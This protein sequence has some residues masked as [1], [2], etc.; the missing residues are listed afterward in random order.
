MLGAGAPAPPAVRQGPL[1][2]GHSQVPVPMAP[3]CNHERYMQ[4]SFMPVHVMRQE[5][6]PRLVDTKVRWTGSL[7]GEM[8]FYVLYA[9]CSC[10]CMCACVVGTVSILRHGRRWVNVG[11]AIP[12]GVVPFSS[13]PPSVPAHDPSRQ[14]VTAPPS[15]R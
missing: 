11:S 9:V 6:L 7:V 5:A 3:L 2:S 1:V 14:M 12:R 15:C 10:V 13:L 4:G 8:L